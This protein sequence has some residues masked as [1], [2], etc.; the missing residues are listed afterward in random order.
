MGYSGKSGPDHQGSS[1]RRR[2]YEG[3]VRPS[4]PRTALVALAVSA[5][6]GLGAA[7]C[8]KAEEPAA[9]ATPGNSPDASAKPT[10]ANTV[11]PGVSGQGSQGGQGQGQST[12]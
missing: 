4:S 3:S 2:G 6:L 5:G 8:T 11:P 10:D 1:G 12:P 7:A 9:P